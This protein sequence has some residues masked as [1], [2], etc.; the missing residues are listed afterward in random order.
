MNYLDSTSPLSARRHDI[1]LYTP[2]GGGGGKDLPP[3]ANRLTSQAVATSRDFIPQDFN[4]LSNGGDFNAAHAQ[5]QLLTPR[6]VLMTPTQMGETLPPCLSQCHTTTAMRRNGDA[7]HCDDRTSHDPFFGG[8]SNIIP[9]LD[10]SRFCA[11]SS[12]GNAA[13]HPSSTGSSS[14]SSSI[15]LPRVH[16]TGGRYPPS[17][18]FVDCSPLDRGPF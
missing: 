11:L 3:N 2:A 9:S 1:G 12:S 10:V 13:C 14:A 18:S 17:P 8:F 15:Y 16:F 7:I 5:Q 6:G 4:H